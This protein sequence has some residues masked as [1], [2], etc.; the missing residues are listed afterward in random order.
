MGAVILQVGQD[1]KRNRDVSEWAVA[2]A[3]R[4]PWQ[5]L[6]IFSQRAV[7]STRRPGKVYSRPVSALFLS[8]PAFIWMKSRQATLIDVSPTRSAAHDSHQ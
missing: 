7:P 5:P 4:D 2:P 8:K 1:G 3:S 6:L